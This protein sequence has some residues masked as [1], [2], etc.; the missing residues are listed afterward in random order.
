[1]PGTIFAASGQINWYR[2]AAPQRS[3]VHCFQQGSPSTPTGAEE[4]SLNFGG[5][6]PAYIN[7]GGNPYYINRNHYAASGGS[8]RNWWSDI[9]AN[10]RISWSLAYDY[11]HWPNTQEY[12][13]FIQ[14]NNPNDYLVDFW[15]ADGFGNNARYENPTVPGAGGNY[16][17]GLNTTR[18]NFTSIAA[19]TGYQLYIFVSDLTNLG[20]PGF[21][22][23]TIDDADG[24]SGLLYNSPGNM[25]MPGG[26]WDNSGAPANLPYYIAHNYNIT[27]G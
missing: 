7:Q 22:D 23:V 20:M 15:I 26:S 18:L 13:I 25:V 2:A 17:M 11:Q 24:V 21:V 3:F 10:S 27:I 9:S 14:N 4:F 6:G 5:N 16:S 19:N 12:Q 1:M 8:G